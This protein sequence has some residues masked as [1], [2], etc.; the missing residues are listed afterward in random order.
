MPSTISEKIYKLVVSIDQNANDQAKEALDDLAN[1]LERLSR[2]QA[3]NASDF[4]DAASKVVSSSQRIVASNQGMKRS[5]S[6]Q[7]QDI[8]ATSNDVANLAKS[9]DKMVDAAGRAKKAG[10]EGIRAGKS[11]PLAA[12]N[13]SDLRESL[14]Q[15]GGGDAKNYS[16]SFSVEDLTDPLANLSMS[17]KKFAGLLGEA[18]REL[19]QAFNGIDDV[20]DIAEQFGRMGKNLKNLGGNLL[21]T[22]GMLGNVARAGGAA[23][24]T[25]PGAT[26]GVIA[27]G[28]AAAVLAPLALAVGGI[29]AALKFF[30]STTADTSTALLS[31]V[32]TQREYYD[33]I[34]KDTTEDAKKTIEQKQKDLETL[35][36]QYAEIQ[37]VRDDAFRTAQKTLFGGDIAA[38][39]G[40]SL[41]EGRDEGYQ[42]LGKRAE[43]LK[44]EI[45]D[46]EFSLGRMKGAVASNKLAANDAAK[47]ISDQAKEIEKSS[48]LDVQMEKMKLSASSEQIQ[49]RL[50]ELSIEKSA[51]QQRLSDLS[52][53][54][55]SNQD[56]KDQT[57]DLTKQLGDLTKE[58]GMLTGEV[59]DAVDQREAEA[60]GLEKL[61]SLI[62]TVIDSRLKSIDDEADA[63][64]ETGK[65]IRNASSD[66]LKDRLLDI[67]EEKAAREAELPAL[68]MA[69]SVSEEGRQKLSEYYAAINK[70]SNE[71]YRLKNIILPL[72]DTRE[73]EQKAIEQTKQAMRDRID[74]LNKEVDIEVQTANQIREGSSENLKA[75]QAEIEIEKSGLEKRLAIMEIL[76]GDDEEAQ[77]KVDEAKQKLKDLNDEQGRITTTILPAV[78]AREAEKEAIDRTKEASQK[79]QDQLDKISSIEEDIT[80]T[81]NDYATETKKIADDRAL[82]AKR[83]EEDFQRGRFK[84]IK[85]F[86]KGMAEEEVDHYK[87]RA[88]SIADFT[89]ESGDEQKDTDKA[90]LKELGDFNKESLRNAEDFQAR[91]RKIEEDSRIE[92]TDAA[93]ELDAKAVYQAMRNRE[94]QIRDETEGYDKDKRRRTEDFDQRLKEEDESQ[95]LARSKRLEAFQQQL[96]DEETQYNEQRAKK[97]AEFNAQLAE[98]DEDR[99]FRANRQAEDYAR[100]DAERLTAFNLQMA[101]LQ[102]NL[103]KEQTLR[104]QYQ[105]DQLTTMQLFYNRLSAQAKNTLNLANSAN[106]SASTALTTAQGLLQRARLTSESKY[107]SSS[108][109]SAATL[110]SLS[111]G[112]RVTRYAS[113][114][115]YGYAG[116]GSPP[117]NQSVLV[118]ENGPE[119]AV[120]GRSTQIFDAGTTSNILGGGFGAGGMSVDMGG[121]TLS[122]GDIGDKSPQDVETIVHSAMLKVFRKIPVTTGRAAK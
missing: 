10:K 17:G 116:G 27:L 70:L 80:K 86:N 13:Q 6:D 57:K 54:D 55:Q 101:Q 16:K 30:D 66:S 35:Q 85:N 64:I 110:Y 69:A 45:G 106:A 120:F 18:G 38:R 56:V 3:D 43:Q 122:F 90:R 40:T 84:A 33:L 100:Q 71:E 48:N 47:A 21:E 99:A 78:Q 46:A 29:V 59:K 83:D 108:P 36:A 67:A 20:G 62:K 50:K 82:N 87:G 15:R 32:N 7:R 26:S 73:A 9:W 5:F 37:G 112:G 75:R 39:I 79:Y 72:V 105:N 111:Q 42:E 107:G 76:A 94:K 25:L 4:E 95:Q 49:E 121:V 96:Q 103:T 117:I 19:N 114:S 68:Q 58:E 1:N 88:K 23:A 22:G 104:D 44:K 109:T 102:A 119:L 77:K 24:A 28:A 31:L 98:E 115:K 74:G 65:Q 52:K 12:T 34:S 92:I 2:A 53:L 14:T 118:G 11:A 93:S 89:K 60:K 41:L 51:A 61:K 113:E 8:A 63:A 91:L 97:V 81:R